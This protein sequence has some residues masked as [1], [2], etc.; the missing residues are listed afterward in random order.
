[1]VL[2][3]CCALGWAPPVS[4]VGKKKMDVWETSCNAPNVISHKYTMELKKHT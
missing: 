1:M 3:V 2:K 4:C